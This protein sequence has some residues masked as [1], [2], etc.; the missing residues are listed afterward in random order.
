MAHVVNGRDGQPK[1]RGIKR[2]NDQVVKAGSILL[3]QCG[4]RFK[5]GRNVGT[6]KDGTLFAL[7]D[8]KVR[9]APNKVVSVIQTAK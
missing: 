4:M 2:Y 8:G 6:G 5:P 1:N 9:F 7:V 3:R